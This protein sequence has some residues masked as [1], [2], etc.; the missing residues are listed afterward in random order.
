MAAWAAAGS[1]PDFFGVARFHAAADSPAWTTRILLSSSRTRR[2]WAA[3][4][5][6]QARACRR[7]R[8]WTWSTAATRGNASSRAGHGSRQRTSKPHGRGWLM[9]KLAGARPN[10]LPGAEAGTV[11]KGEPFRESRRK[12]GSVEGRR[13]ARPPPRATSCELGLPPYEAWPAL[14]SNRRRAPCPPRE[15]EVGPA[16]PPLLLPATGADSGALVHQASHAAS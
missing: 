10:R 12:G 1:L 3:R 5:A 9:A 16:S 15:H 6:W 11:P 14:R 2:S 4:R 8:C 13:G 7:K